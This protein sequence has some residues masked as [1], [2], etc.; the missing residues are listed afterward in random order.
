M[1]STYLRQPLALSMFL[2]VIVKGCGMPLNYEPPPVPWAETWKTAHTCAKACDAFEEIEP[3]WEVFD[4]P[5]LNVLEERALDG[6]QTLEEAFQRMRQARAT[7]AANYPG[8]PLVRLMPSYNNQ[9]YLAQNPIPTSLIPKSFRFQQVT[10]S[11]P[12]VINYEVD[13]W[14]KYNHTYFGYA[15]RACASQYDWYATWLLLTTDVAQAYFLL[16]TFDTEQQLLEHSLQL[17][18]QN[19]DTQLSRY[20]EG[21]TTLL[22]VSASETLLAQTQADLEDVRRQRTLQENLLAL[23]CGDPAPDFC[24]DLMPLDSNPPCISADLPS[25]VLLRRPDIGQAEQTMAAFYHDVGVS[26]AS[27]FPSLSLTGQLGYQSPELSNWFSWQGRLWSLGVQASQTIFDN[28]RNQCN[29]A[30]AKA[31][32]CAEVA[33]YRQQVLTAFQEVENALSNIQQRDRA[34]EALDRFVA[35]TETTA[36]L[37]EH[38]YMDGINNILDVVTARRTQLDAE[39][40][41]VQIRGQRFVDAVQLVKALGGAW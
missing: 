19:Y 12:L 37:T 23:L 20:K 14:D 40:A 41:A 29:L 39:R 3:W 25:E 26:Y 8:T 24:L 6:S 15:S 27:L 4:D 10:Q 5:M 17:L 22:D 13:I 7:S 2:A 21:I 38:R 1:R 11:F 16:R 33:A 31:A 35:A 34:L 32:Y 36:N 9:D 30:A 28:G 18:Q